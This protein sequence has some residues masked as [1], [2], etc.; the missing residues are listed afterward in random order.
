MEQ[1]NLKSKSNMIAEIKNSLKSCTP[2]NNDIVTAKLLT[3]NNL[4]NEN[5]NKAV[6]GNINVVLRCRPF[7][8][9]EKKMS[10]YIII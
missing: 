6:G 1:R 7:N 4:L 9:K 10:K 3:N 8:E 5:T 2:Q